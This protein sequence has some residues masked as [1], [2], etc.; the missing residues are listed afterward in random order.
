MIVSELDSQTIDGEFDSSGFML[1]K[2][3]LIKGPLIFFVALVFFK[4][5]PRRTMVNEQG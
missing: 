4:W 1:D 2:T 3:K 5:A